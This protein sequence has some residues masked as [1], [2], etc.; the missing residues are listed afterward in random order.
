MYKQN[1][2]IDDLQ[3][4]LNNALSNIMILL[5]NQSNKQEEYQALLNENRNLI[6]ENEYLK[7]TIEELFP[8]KEIA[9][10]LMKLHIEQCE[11]K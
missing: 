6:E 1:E 9:Y 8:Y 3:S 7:K 2:K 5:E 4:K 11:N 10:N